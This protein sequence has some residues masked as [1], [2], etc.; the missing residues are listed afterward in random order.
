MKERSWTIGQQIAVGFGISLLMV[1]LLGV[2]SFRSTKAMLRTSYEVDEA[3]ASLVDLEQFLSSLK[4]AESGQRG[5]VITGQEA[6][7]APY[8]AA[9]TVVQKE[10]DDL[11]ALIS[12]SPTQRQRLDKLKPELDAKLAEMRDVIELRRREGPEAAG[13]GRWT[14]SARSSP[15]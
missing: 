15:R 2:S 1:L 10:L 8:T 4:D 6:L 13:S 9:V 5:Y 11:T 3:H 7:L 14:R 12:D